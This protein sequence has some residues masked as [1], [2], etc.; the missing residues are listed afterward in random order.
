MKIKKHIAEEIALSKEN[1]H[2]S[3]LIDSKCLCELF[4]FVIG[5]CVNYSYS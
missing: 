1:A 3:L 4:I 2:S 5:V